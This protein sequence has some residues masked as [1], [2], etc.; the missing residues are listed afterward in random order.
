MLNGR[1]LSKKTVRSIAGIL[2]FLAVGGA[3]GSFISY[4]VFGGKG[5]AQ[6]PKLS[7][8][9]APPEKIG[10]VAPATLHPIGLSPVPPERSHDHR[11]AV[12]GVGSQ[13]PLNIPWADPYPAHSFT[14]TDQNG[15]Q[16]SLKDFSGKVVLVNFIYTHCK[17]VCPLETQELK[18]LQQTLEP[19]MGRDVI[20]LS[21]TIDP[22]RDT[23]AVLRRYGEGY[24]VDFKSWSFLT[25]SE[26]KIR[27]VLTAYRVPVELEK[28][29]DAPEGSYEFGHGSPIYFIDQWGRVRTRTA[30]T[31]LPRIGQQAIEHLV[32]EGAGHVHGH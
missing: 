30:L 11:M 12:E 23:P 24:G 22:T 7:E 17:T 13:T 28:P 6:I 16:I 29:P 18:R 31:M 19:L 25:G 15:N 32:H 1:R 5:K 21:I 27:E 3:A 2:V 26:A 14:L 10:E 9:A 20:F 8:I 4:S